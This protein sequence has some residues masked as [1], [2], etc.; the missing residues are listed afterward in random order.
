[1][2]NEGGWATMK[3][4]EG[5]GIKDVVASGPEVVGLFSLVVRKIGARK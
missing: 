2:Q 5:E 3:M 1:M 4:V